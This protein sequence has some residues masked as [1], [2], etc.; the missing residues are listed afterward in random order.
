MLDTQSE[1]TLYQQIY[2]DIKQKISSGEYAEGQALPSEA[3]LCEIYGVSRVTVRAAIAEL[4][5]N[6]MVVKKHGK[7]TF[8]TRKKLDS[9]LFRFEGFTTACRRNNVEISTHVLTI[10]EQ[11]PTARDIQLLK[12]T[13]DDSIVYI[14][15]LR[16]AN[17]IPV[18][19]EHVRLSKKKY[20]FLLDCDLENK[21]LYATLAEHTGANPEDYCNVSIMLEAGAATTEEARLLNIR[22][23]MPLFILRETVAS[24]DTNEPVHWTKQL[25]SGSYFQFTLSNDESKLGLQ[26]AGK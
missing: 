12:L 6:E 21:S 11:K 13:A 14:N 18:V 26:L 25:M 17:G 24:S 20:G 3:K 22:K 19:I 7:G 10:E 23:G 4:A 8:V 2:D 16:Y 5:E 1:V 15:R 9:S